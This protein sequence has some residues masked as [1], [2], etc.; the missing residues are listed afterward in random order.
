MSEFELSLKEFCFLMDEDCGIIQESLSGTYKNLKYRIDAGNAYSGQQK[1]VHVGPYAWH[2]DGTR[3]HA[4]QWP[5]TPPTR[6]QK[7]AAA[8]ALNI[9]MQML[10]SYLLKD[11]LVII[12]TND[13]NTQLLMESYLK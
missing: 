10:E 3:S 11:Y 6:K 5:S 4:S 7:Q 8:Q 13:K 12:S 1:H 9:S 2:Q